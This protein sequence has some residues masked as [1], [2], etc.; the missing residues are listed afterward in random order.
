[1]K[2]RLE[3]FTKT[4]REQQIDLCEEWRNVNT[5]D[6]RRMTWIL[7]TIVVG[8]ILTFTL[9]V[10]HARADDQRR[11]KRLWTATWRHSPQETL[12]N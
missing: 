4:L 12:T 2:H 3:R 9:G 10:G 5:A 11:S 6:M 7:G 1:M 8:G